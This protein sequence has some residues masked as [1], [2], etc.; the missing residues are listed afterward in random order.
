MTSAA[1]EG[2]GHA[3]PPAAEASVRAPPSEAGP[4]DA[5]APRPLA[6]VLLVGLALAWA[7]WTMAPLMGGD[8]WQR[9][10]LGHNGA[11]YAHIGWNHARFDWAYAGAP[12][13]SVTPAPGEDVAPDVYGHHPPGVGWLLGALFAAH[14]DVPDER[15]ARRSAAAASLLGLLAFALLVRRAGGGLRAG[16]AACVVA[17]MPMT[18]V[19][20][21]HVEVQG[22][23]VL[24]A[25]VLTLL[26]YGRWRDGGSWLPFALAA[27]LASAFDWYGLYA[28]A[29]C[30][31]HLL[32]GPGR[33]PAAACAVGAGTLAVFGGWLLW[34]GSLPGM[35]V[36]R[37]FGAAGVRG[38]GGL[39]DASADASRV[40]AYLQAWWADSL[41]LMPVWPV[42]LGVGLL[43]L[44]LRWRASRRDPA[45]TGGVAR[46]GPGWTVLVLLGP[47][48]LH[49]ALFPAGMLVH[50]YWLFGLPLGL[51]AGLVLAPAVRAR[52]LGLV[53][54][55]MALGFGLGRHGDGHPPGD[56]IPALMGS[57]LRSN[58]RPGEVV[59]TNYD[60]NV[61]RDDRPGPAYL[62]KR[63]EVPYYA[64]RIV[65]G[66]VGVPGE[67]GA[68]VALDEAL[69]RL[70]AASAFL[71]V[72]VPW[73]A[74][75]V[76][77][78]ALQA[79]LRERAHGE[80]LVLSGAPPVWLWRLRAP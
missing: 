79:A 1:G 21:A 67:P 6:F 53:A 80:P 2:P 37:V 45:P 55:G 44:G 32:V 20:G 16:L 22:P 52:H 50:A 15:L 35:T 63:P 43:G 31:L 58:T 30:A 51:A 3:D 49:G 11:R 27:V 8:P 9:G 41:Q 78:P 66:G 42:W 18:A 12:L 60:T 33:R 71:Q 64:D 69:A 59:L 48:V 13:L 26:A 25:S 46:L 14:G 34:L 28:P 62:S 29:F 74:E 19:Y 4:P 61:L 17:A 77:S 72:P 76:L 24:A 39:G 38:A 73:T 47:P 70:P 65:R 68:V 75:A 7:A 57:A 5:P 56:P 36:A 54:A 23:Y 10:W 40:D